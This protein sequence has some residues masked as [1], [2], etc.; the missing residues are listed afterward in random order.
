MVIRA[1]AVDGASTCGTG[2]DAELPS[3]WATPSLSFAALQFATRRP[4][5]GAAGGVPRKRS[6]FGNMRARTNAVVHAGEGK[7]PIFEK[8]ERRLGCEA[9]NGR[10]PTGMATDPLFDLLYRVLPTWRPTPATLLPRALET[11]S[12]GTQRG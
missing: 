3:A 1:R 9:S 5:R 8:V 12:A 4:V 2:G 6:G 11:G 7:G 10:I